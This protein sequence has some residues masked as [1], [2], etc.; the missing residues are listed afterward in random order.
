MLM[1]IFIINHIAPADYLSK[2]QRVI[3]TA[4]ETS[5]EVIVPIAIDNVVEGA[6]QFTATLSPVDGSIGVE[7]RQG[8]ATATI[9]DDDSKFEKCTHLLDRLLHS[10][11]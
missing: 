9:I 2:T 3:F 7:I 1:S 4:K 11:Q 5:K 8:N 6:E 10:L